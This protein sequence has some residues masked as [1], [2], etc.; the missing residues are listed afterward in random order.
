MVKLFLGREIGINDAITPDCAIGA[1]YH[2]R[3]TMIGLRPEHHIDHRF[4]THQFRTFGLRNTTGN[5]DNHLVRAIGFL[6]FFV[7]T[8]TAKIGKDLLSS[9]FADVA[10][11]EDN[12][13]GTCGIVDRL[14][15]QRRQYVL[16]ALAVINIHLTAIGFYKKL[17][18]HTHFWIRF[19][20]S[21]IRRK[22][23]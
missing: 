7:F 4:A 9:L 15:T 12:H 21:R 2:F 16:H 10:S 14:V 3:Q 8:N 17:F 1:R 13:I 20:L 11:I 5:S 19:L 22:A 23:V 18:R 6:G